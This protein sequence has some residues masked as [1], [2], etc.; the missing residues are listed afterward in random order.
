MK[1]SGS[2]GDF[3]AESNVSPCKGAQSGRKVLGGGPVPS[4]ARARR[5]RTAFLRTCRRSG[6]RG[7]L[8]VTAMWMDGGQVGAGRGESGGRNQ[9][10]PQSHSPI[11]TA[12]HWAQSRLEKGGECVLQ[13][14]RA[15]FVTKYYSKVPTVEM[16]SSS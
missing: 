4:E 3:R 8:K 12:I 10:S 14:K 13:I 16:E 6:P 15:I 1:E 7:P 2:K 5:G 11:S 9:R